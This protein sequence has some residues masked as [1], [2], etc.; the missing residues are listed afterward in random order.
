MHTTG[1]ILG[2]VYIA[3]I[4][5]TIVR[6]LLDTHSTPKTLGYLL[7]VIIASGYRDDFLLRVWYQLSPS[8][9]H[10]KRYHRT[11]GTRQSDFQ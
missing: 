9:L 6:I 8:E 7:L 5:F 1:I 2:I 4:V 10:K 11:A 3:A